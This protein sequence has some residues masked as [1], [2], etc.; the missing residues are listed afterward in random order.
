[1]LKSSVLRTKLARVAFALPLI[2]ATP[3]LDRCTPVSEPK[4]SNSGYCELTDAR[5]LNKGFVI[6]VLS[7]KDCPRC[8]EM[9]KLLDELKL[10]LQVKLRVFSFDRDSED[11]LHQQ[12]EKKLFARN[13]SAVSG[14]FVYDTPTVVFLKDGELISRH[15]G[16]YGNSTELK[17]DLQKYFGITL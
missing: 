9:D 2:F 1:M 4:C 16:T 10:E 13:I 15:I 11:L 14:I 6:A 3:M 8:R 17:A 12:I 5:Q 7:A